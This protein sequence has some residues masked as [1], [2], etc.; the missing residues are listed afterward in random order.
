MDYSF[1]QKAKAYSRFLRE[2]ARVNDWVYRVG[3]ELR[4]HTKY[5]AL[6]LTYNEAHLPERGVCRRDV[7]LFMKRLRKHIGVKV[8]A[9]G[10]GEYGSKG[11]RPHY[12]L[13]VFGWRPDDLVYHHTTDHGVKV[14]L[15]DTVARLWSIW[16]QPTKEKPVGHYDPIGFIGVSTDISD[17]TIPYFCKYMQKFNTLPRG[18]ARPFSII[19]RGIGLCA[20]DYRGDQCMIDFDYDRM[21]Y[22]GKS[23]RISRYF[24]DHSPDVAFYVLGERKKKWDVPRSFFSTGD[25]VYDYISLDKL[26]KFDGLSY[27][28]FSWLQ[29]GFENFL[30]VFGKELDKFLRV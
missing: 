19:S 8:K 25:N 23:R 11:Q 20:L 10:C 30:K 29:R 15:S 12:H 22:H 13:I 21:Y 4:A 7:Q 6:T 17:N 18:Y 26:L 24:L 14:Y 27:S 28:H 1:Y 3:Y 9:F 2:R 16:V 5:C